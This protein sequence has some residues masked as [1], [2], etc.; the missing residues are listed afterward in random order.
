MTKDLSHSDETHVSPKFLNEIGEHF[1][2]I[3]RFSK[4][5]S[6]E[7][8]INEPIYLWLSTSVQWVKYTRNVFSISALWFDHT[9]CLPN[10]QIVFG[11]CFVVLRH[12][13]VHWTHS[14][15]RHTFS[16][17]P[18]IRSFK[19]LIMSKMWLRNRWTSQPF[20]HCNRKY[21]TSKGQCNRIAS[22]AEPANC[23]EKNATEFITSN[24]GNNA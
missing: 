19:R 17:W 11:V 6:F 16:I 24:R 7:S 4:Q 9:I 18:A 14:K 10:D 8:P 23:N 12:T 3:N 21:A 22:N 20:V 13:S 2:K 5:N 1:M 15:A